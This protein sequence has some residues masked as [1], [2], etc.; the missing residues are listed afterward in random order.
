[1]NF[2][3]I[4]ASRIFEGK[5]LPK[6]LRMGKSDVRECKQSTPYGFESNPVKDTIAVYSETAVL[7]DDVIIGYIPKEALTEDGESRVFSTDENGNLKVYIHLKANGDIEFGGTAG[8]LTRYQE[9]ETAFNTLKQD[10]NNLVNAFNTH[11]HPTAATGPPSTPTPVP[12]VIPATPST[13][14]ITGAKIDEFKTL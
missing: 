5:I 4:T 7:G 8:N 6:F 2:V 3:K 1:M 14:D 13:A 12:T 11:V 9:L 10:F